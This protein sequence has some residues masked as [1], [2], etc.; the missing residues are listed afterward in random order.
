MEII[1]LRLS[2]DLIL[3]STQFRSFEF[4]QTLDLFLGDYQFEAMR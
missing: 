3:N 1:L 2:G 4:Q